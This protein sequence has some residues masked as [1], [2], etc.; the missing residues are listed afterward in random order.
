MSRLLLLLPVVFLLGCSH[1][2]TLTPR[3]SDRDYARVNRKARKFCVQHDKTCSSGTC[4][5][6]S[7]RSVY[8]TLM[9]GREIEVYDLSIGR[10]KTVYCPYGVTEEIIST[11]EIQKVDLLRESKGG[12][13][14]TRTGLLGGAVVGVG[15]AAMA[16]D[17]TQS[18]QSRIN[19][20][21]LIVA[22]G[23]L[24]GGAVGWM[25]E[26]YLD[27]DDVSIYTVKLDSTAQDRH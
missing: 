7:D 3:S 8:M 16:D 24:L 10:V 20:A 21:A 2:C 9:D 14:D 26:H 23:A 18:T 6:P 25:A 4:A 1:T 12:L 17:S 11:W 22:G 13:V 5:A 15:L 27:S 19:Q